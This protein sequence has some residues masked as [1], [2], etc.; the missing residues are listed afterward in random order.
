MFHRTH[1]RNG[2][3]FFF[4]LLHSPWYIYNMYSAYSTVR[5]TQKRKERKKTTQLTTTR[6]LSLRLWQTQR[7]H[8]FVYSLEKNCLVWAKQEHFICSSLNAGNEDKFIQLKP[9]RF[10]RADQICRREKTYFQSLFINEHRTSPFSNFKIEIYFKFK[11]NKLF[12]AFDSV[13]GMHAQQCHLWNCKYPYASRPINGCIVNYVSTYHCE[14]V[15]RY[16]F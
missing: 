11:F 5:E 6:P 16:L 10:C 12:L 1:Y 3:L 7:F 4:R 2:M 8:L 13:N 9:L 14:S 15:G